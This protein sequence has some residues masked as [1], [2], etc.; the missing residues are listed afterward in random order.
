MR[1]ESDRDGMAGLLSLSLSLSLSPAYS[2][3]QN[4][5]AQLCRICRVTGSR[6]LD[7]PPLISSAAAVGTCIA[8]PALC[9]ELPEAVATGAIYHECGASRVSVA[10]VSTVVPTVVL[11]VKRY[12]ARVVRVIGRQWPNGPNQLAAPSSPW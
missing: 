4:I 10:Y 12:G 9:G 2:C 6:G 11:V 7:G 1:G 5:L 8:G 3:V